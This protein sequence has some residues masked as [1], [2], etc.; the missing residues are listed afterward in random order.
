MKNIA[1][2][3]RREKEI[4]AVKTLLRLHEDEEVLRLKL[5]QSFEMSEEAV[6]KRVASGSISQEK[7]RESM[8]MNTNSNTN[9]TNNTNMSSISRFNSSSSS[10]SSSNGNED[11]INSNPRANTMSMKDRGFSFSGNSESESENEIENSTAGTDSAP[12]DR[13]GLMKRSGGMYGRRNSNFVEVHVNKDNEEDC[14]KDEPGGSGKNKNRSK[15]IGSGRGRLDRSDSH[16]DVNDVNLNNFKYAT[17]RGNNLQ[18]Y[19]SALTNHQKKGKKDEE[20]I[21]SVVSGSSGGSDGAT[22]SGL[23]YEFKLEHDNSHIFLWRSRW[24]YRLSLEIGLLLQC[25]YIAIWATQIIVVA[26]NTEHYSVWWSLGLTVPMF[27]NF[28]MLRDILVSV[29]YTSTIYIY[30]YIFCIF[31]TIYIYCIFYSNTV[32]SYILYIFV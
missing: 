7:A 1:A 13:R 27:V 6:R 8:H 28:L 32:Y 11:S 24:L 10:A 26:W 16:N 9:N 25:F 31:Y 23:Q 21:G 20:P 3:R 29:I 17:S 5:L 12:I 30:N 22:M 2:E 15:S 14:L 18:Q 4:A 19:Y